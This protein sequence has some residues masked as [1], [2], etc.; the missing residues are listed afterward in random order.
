MLT[1]LPK[2]ASLIKDERSLEYD[3]LT[4][5]I[6]K[7][8]IE[9]SLYRLAT[10]I[11]FL[12]G[13]YSVHSFNQEEKEKLFALLIEY[14]LQKYV[15]ST[16][17]LFQTP[18]TPKK[19]KLF[20]SAFTKKICNNIQIKY[21]D[22]KQIYDEVN[23][24]GLDTTFDNT[25]QQIRRGIQCL[26]EFFAL[27]RHLIPPS[28]FPQLIDN[29]LQGENLNQRLF[30]VVKSEPISTY[31]KSFEMLIEFKKSS[32]VIR[33]LDPFLIAQL[34]SYRPDLPIDNYLDFILEDIYNSFIVLLLNIQN[35]SIQAPIQI[36]HGGMRP[37]DFIQPLVYLIGSSQ[38]RSKVWDT[39]ER[40][41]LVISDLIHPNN[42]TSNDFVFSFFYMF[43]KTFVERVEAQNQQ[44]DKNQEQDNVLENNIFTKDE[45]LFLQDE[46]MNDMDEEEEEEDEDSN[47]KEKVFDKKE[48]MIDQEGIDKF[49][50]IVKPHLKYLIY[51]KNRFK[52]QVA[53]IYKSLCK[54]RP[55]EI[56]PYVMEQIQLALERD[57]MKPL[58]IIHI[59]EKIFRPA[60]QFDQYP[61]II[62]Y[63]P[64]ILRQTTNF[65]LDSGEQ[66]WRFYDILF[67]YIP[68]YDVKDL[69]AQYPNLNLQEEM[70][71]DD[72]NFYQ[73][74]QEISDLALEA[75]RKYVSTFEYSDVKYHTS[76]RGSEIIFSTRNK[77]YNFVFQSSKSNYKE[78]VNI[79]CNYLDDKILNNLSDNF[80]LLLQAI[81]LRD[82][83][84]LKDVLTVIQNQLLR[85]TKD[86]YEFNIS[87]I[88]TIRNYL[89]IIYEIVQ[90][91][92]SVNKQYYQILKCI[93]D[94]SLKH[95][96]TKIQQAGQNILACL[97]MSQAAI[98]IR[99]FQF[100]NDPTIQ[101]DW[102]K[103]KQKGKQEK[104][105]PKW[106]EIDD[107]EFIKQIMDDYY[108]PALQQIREII[109][110]KGDNKQFLD[111][112]QN[113]F[114]SQYEQQYQLDTKQNCQQIELKIRKNLSL[115][116]DIIYAFVRPLY[117]RMK[118]YNQNSSEAFKKFQDQYCFDVLNQMYNEVI[119][120]CV[121]F[122]PVYIN[123]GLALDGKLATSF[124]NIIKLLIHET[125]DKIQRLGKWL[126]VKT[127]SSD[128]NKI[129]FYNRFQSQM[130]YTYLLNNRIDQIYYNQI[131]NQQ[132]K[133]MLLI[134]IPFLFDSNEFSYKVNWIW[135]SSRMELLDDREWLYELFKKLYEQLKT[136]FKNKWFNQQ[137]IETLNETEKQKLSL[138]QNHFTKGFANFVSIVSNLNPGLFL[139][140]YQIFDCAYQNLIDKVNRADFNLDVL[141]L[142]QKISQA[143]V[144]LNQADFDR[145]HILI[146]KNQEVLKYV[147]S[148][149]EQRHQYWLEQQTKISSGLVSLNEKLNSIVEFWLSIPIDASTSRQ[150]ISN[151]CA[152]LLMRTEQLPQLN[153]RVILKAF[154]CCI[155]QEFN[156]RSLG[157][158]LLYRL[159]QICVFKH[160]SYKYIIRKPEDFQNTQINLDQYNVYRF[161][162]PEDQKYYKLNDYHRKGKI[163]LYNSLKYTDIKREEAKKQFK[164]LKSI[165]P[166]QWHQFI[167]LMIID[168]SVLDQQQSQ[169]PIMLFQFNQDK[170]SIANLFNDVDN[171]ANEQFFYN[172]YM[173]APIRFS[174][175]YK[176]VQ[177]MK[178]LFAITDYEIFNHTKHLIDQNNLDQ[179]SFQR[180]YLSGLLYALHSSWDCQYKQ[181]IIDYCIDK[182]EKI[183][184]DQ[185][186]DEF[187]TFQY[188]LHAALSRCDLR[189]QEQFLISILDKV[190]KENDNKKLRWIFLFYT[191]IESK[192]H[193]Q[194][195]L[196]ENILQTNVDYSNL[197]AVQTFI[198]LI[199][200]QQNKYPHNIELLQE[201]GLLEQFRQQT[202]ILVESKYFIFEN[203]ELFSKGLN[204]LVNQFQQQNINGKINI[205]ETLFEGW[206]SKKFFI[207]PYIL[208]KMQPIVEY[209]LTI[210]EENNLQ[211]LTQGLQI[212]SNIRI[213]EC[214]ITLIQMTLNLLK[215]SQNAVR[216][217]QL[218]FL[219]ILTKEILH[220]NRPEILEN[221]VQYL[222]D[223]NKIVMQS[224][225]ELTTQLI[226]Q[227][228]L[229]E[230]NCQLEIYLK[231]AT[232]K[233]TELQ[234]KQVLMAM[235]MAHPRYTQSW[236]NQALKVV[237]EK[238]N[239]LQQQQK[240]FAANYLKL[241]R[242][243]QLMEI[244][245]VQIQIEFIEKMS[246]LSNPYNYFA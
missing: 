193:Q 155:S 188:Y 176:K 107:Q 147:D 190:Q 84:V 2:C 104:Y 162:L 126:Q 18:C 109:T 86:H 163:L 174:L 4:K 119:Q 236:I 38:T 29:Y 144:E 166:E 231:Q 19:I 141:S 72:I 123:N 24:N 161:I 167:N 234:G 46:E 26:Q 125:S 3:R 27:F 122:V 59:I 113:D 67:Q 219:K 129:K 12:Q 111:Y 199:I 215:I 169:Q 9:N 201:F 94:L 93:I 198:P 112:L 76:Q 35:L 8:I 159:I 140:S 184:M 240:T 168:Q 33:Q 160:K 228:T 214:T 244:E 170:S 230:V 156:I 110:Q 10:D 152:L 50:S 63:I 22:L 134:S 158:L 55:K 89:I 142:V 243:N 177:F 197:K 139:D 210:N 34:I 66:I 83:N 154:N 241:Y 146:I 32:H 137:Y 70:K 1:H 172:S 212:F 71:I 78:I 179:L 87:N 203:S 49:I 202:A 68:I 53:G 91:S 13:F 100:T 181:E 223:E 242:A 64:F 44:Q 14:S 16:K 133:E 95:E 45:Q 21:E 130:F 101:L 120:F 148:I 96:E 42:A 36:H 58:L 149:F 135:L 118:Q 97:L 157:K 106:Q 191:I 30:R 200:D 175:L 69:E 82:P 77:F 48:F 117:F 40:M 114:L 194:I 43:V 217:R 238:Q 180:I 79:V 229:Q 132:N 52:I 208:Q 227:M 235:I 37:S 145:K 6:E 171:Q 131:M 85:Q 213:K 81:I 165:S 221:I 103:L 143:S 57:D 31:T 226:Q 207:N 211:Q 102:L 189:K 39:I 61:Q 233:D 222:L 220:I 98:H 7:S 136:V 115:N 216:V 51:Q 15:Y 245:D 62:N 237:L 88:T 153:E 224:C 17:H 60:I 54:L 90:F 187:K 127:R 138:F 124:I 74:T 178:Y 116:L 11:K 183:I 75:F 23:Q 73:I 105:I 108:H 209:L 173:Q 186:R 196:L 195:K 92:G 41:F 185:S 232:N 204:I 239:K 99:D 151:G 80:V 192:K 47:D 121:D 25:D 56:L 218:N 28:Y 164:I 246:E 206:K 20:L 182:F 65:I 5:R 128:T 225:F 150:L 205:I